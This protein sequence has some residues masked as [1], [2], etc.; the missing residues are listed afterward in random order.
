MPATRN[1]FV[2]SF[3]QGAYASLPSAV[4][5]RYVADLRAAERWELRMDAVIE[6]WSRA[7][8]L[9]SRPAAAH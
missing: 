5:E 6:S 2:T 4:R 9:F 7:K 1:E 8:E 3:W